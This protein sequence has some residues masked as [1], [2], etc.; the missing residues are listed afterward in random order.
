MLM[1]VVGG[2]RGGNDH[3]QGMKTRMANM[4]ITATMKIIFVNKVGTVCE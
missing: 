3:C 2:G 1:M 4:I